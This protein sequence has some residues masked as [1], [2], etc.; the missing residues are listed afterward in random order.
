MRLS[1]MASNVLELTRVE[2]QMILTDVKNF[3]LSEQIRACVLLFE[4][5][6]SKKNIEMFIDLDEYM[7]SANEGLLKQVWRNLI[8]NAIEF[9]PEYG[10]VM[11]RIS[12]SG[13]ILSIAVSNSGEQIPEEARSKIF[14]KFYQA[15]ESHSTEGNGIGLAIVKKVVELHKGTI[16]VESTDELTTFTVELPSDVGRLIA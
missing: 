5:K 14:N 9:T 6:W 16:S 10:A 13:N 7:I 12:Q 8:D 15:D 4:E 3:N 1:Y 11:V 2:N